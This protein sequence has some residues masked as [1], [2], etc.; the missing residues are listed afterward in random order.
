MSSPTGSFPRIS[1]TGNFLWGSLYCTNKEFLSLPPT[2]PV[3]PTPQT[4]EAV[5]ALVGK[6]GVG[7][8]QAGRQWGVGGQGADGK[9]RNRRNKEVLWLPL[10]L[11]MPG[12]CLLT[13]TRW[14]AFTPYVACSFTH[15]LPDWTERRHLDVNVGSA[16]Q[17]SPLNQFPHEYQGGLRWET[18]SPQCLIN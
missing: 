7:M 3:S 16:G 6:R 13:G 8:N 4:A 12:N 18:R 2:L 1:I 17:S 10:A 11:E 9:G 5:E 15:Y 14:L